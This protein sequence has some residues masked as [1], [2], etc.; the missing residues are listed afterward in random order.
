MNVSAN[1]EGKGWLPGA[2]ATGPRGGKIKPTENY[3]YRTN[4]PGRGGEGGYLEY[5][6]FLKE[7]LEKIEGKNYKYFP[8]AESKNYDFELLYQYLA[9]GEPRVHPFNA[10]GHTVCRIRTVLEF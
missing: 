3:D 5:K 1:A 10:E 8:A 2:L 7:A 4:R 6:V 9:G